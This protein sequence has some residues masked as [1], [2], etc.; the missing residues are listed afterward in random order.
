MAQSLIH[1]LLVYSFDAGRLIREEEF[2]DTRMAVTAYEAA[3]AEFRNSDE[4]ARFEVVLVGA[5][6][7]ETVM[8]THGH[9]FKD[10]DEAMFADLLASH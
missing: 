7:I 4:V 8:R 3:E 6:S 9:Y 5:D 2:T 10:A 1:F